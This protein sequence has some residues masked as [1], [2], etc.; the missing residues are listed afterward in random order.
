VSE[1]LIRDLFHR[2]ERI[3]PEEQKLIMVTAD[4]SV[5][6]ALEVMKRNNLS[7][8]PILAGSSVLGVFSYRSFSEG[9]L[10]LSK[11]ERAE[12][13]SLP[14]EG[15]SEDLKY[16]QMQ[17]ELN[18]IIREFDA[19]DAVLI[20]SER[21]LQGIVTTVDA[22]RYFYDLASAYIML[23]EIEL[24]IRELLRAS[25][26]AEGLK[27]CIERCIAEVYTKSG[28]TV[29]SGLDEMC[30]GD[31][32]TILKFKGFWDVHF[33]DKFGGS[34]SLAQAKLDRLPT[35]RND[36]FHFKR[37]LTQEDYNYL[38]DAREWVLKRAL[39]LDSEHQG[40]KHE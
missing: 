9:I 21:G 6:D 36:V 27:E 32:I 8:L 4:T 3:L 7:Q 28:Q 40:V 17:D 15:F 29:P 13:S 31:Y 26:D 18:D 33:K 12:I 2:V 10:K 37:D 38:K 34:Y 14:V 16:A 23:R 30:L 1:H 19:R 11:R 25:V 20:G 35:L 22:L 24:A 5:H 39:K